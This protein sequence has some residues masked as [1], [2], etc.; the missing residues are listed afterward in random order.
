LDRMYYGLHL[1]Q[2][3]NKMYFYMLL[4]LEKSWLISTVILHTCGY[5]YGSMG[6]Q[7]RSEKV[8]VRKLVNLQRRRERRWLRGEGGLGRRTGAAGA[9]A[10]R[11]RRCWGGL[12]RVRERLGE[13]GQ[14]AVAGTR[15]GAQAGGGGDAGWPALAQDWVG[16]HARWR[17]QQ[18]RERLGGEQRR[19]EGEATR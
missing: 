12:T 9:A 15:G 7:I 5:I 3:R 6:Y 11:A 10:G 19:R 8:R 17:C 18:R 4:R 16:W 14:P 13:R 1:Y 2:I